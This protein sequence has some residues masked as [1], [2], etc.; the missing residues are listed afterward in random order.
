MYLKIIG[1]FSFSESCMSWTDEHILVALVKR[2]M[3]LRLKMFP[4]FET[5]SGNSR[6]VS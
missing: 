4:V 1:M 2:L 6:I 5:A 3:Y